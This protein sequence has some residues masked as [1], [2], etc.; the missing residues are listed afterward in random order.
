MTVK[1]FNQNS[2]KNDQKNLPNQP[3]KEAPQLGVY[4][5]N[6]GSIYSKPEEVQN[7]LNWIKEQSDLKSS[8][9]STN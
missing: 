6:D 2:E 5:S 9:S 7:L 4:R 8:K 1:T 3:P